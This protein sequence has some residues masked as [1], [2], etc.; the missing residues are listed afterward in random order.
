M[1]VVRI[2]L[3]AVGAPIAA[4]G[5]VALIY[6][7]FSHPE[8]DVPQSMGYWVGFSLLALGVGL[9]FVGQAVRRDRI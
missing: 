6:T 5:I 7:P 4:L 9:C 2:V 3:L 8:G 1:A